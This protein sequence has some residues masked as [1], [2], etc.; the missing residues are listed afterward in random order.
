MIIL[1]PAA[2]QRHESLTVYP[3]LSPDGDGLGYLLF[4]D[5]IRAGSLRHARTG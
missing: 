5:A 1:S 4:P 2:P 3:L